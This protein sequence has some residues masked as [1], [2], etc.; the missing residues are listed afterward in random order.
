M[1]RALGLIAGARLSLFR[2]PYVACVVG[3]CHADPGGPIC[4]RPFACS[5]ACRLGAPLPRWL[6][7]VGYPACGDRRC[8]VRP[9][10][11]RCGRHWQWQEPYLLA[12]S[13]C[14]VGGG[15]QAGRG[16]S[17]GRGSRRA[18]HRPR[19]KPACIDRAASSQLARGWPAAAS[20][21][22]TLRPTDPAG[23][24]H[25][26]GTVQPCSSTPSPGP[27]AIG[28]RCRCAYLFSLAPTFV[29]P[30]ARLSAAHSGSVSSGECQ[31]G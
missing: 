16:A 1:V 20:A 22:R 18:V 31:P 17:A 30:R 10:R 23:P 15:H 8:C 27:V 2:V 19:G 12:A 9:R 26:D 21:A 7:V 4:V 25:E 13:H 28:G 14:P 3:T 6:D 11:A 29:V 5:R 24:D